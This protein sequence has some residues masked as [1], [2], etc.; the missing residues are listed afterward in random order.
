MAWADLWLSLPREWFSLTQAR[1]P[2][3]GKGVSGGPCKL[4]DSRKH[5]A[6]IL[7]SL[8]LPDGWGNVDL[9][10]QL[11]LEARNNRRLEAELDA[12]GPSSGVVGAAR[13][14][15]GL[16]ALAQ[17][18]PSPSWLRGLVTTQSEALRCLADQQAGLLICSD[19]LE[20]GNGFALVAEALRQ[21]PDL[22]VLMILSERPPNGR[23][24]VQVGCTAVILEAE[25]GTESQPLSQALQATASGVPYRSA[26]VERLLAAPANTADADSMA[27]LT[28]REE[29]VLTLIISG[30][31]DVEIA[32]RLCL[33]PQTV[34]GYGKDIR[35][36]FGAR[37]RV[38]RLGK[39]LRNAMG[40]RQR[41][42]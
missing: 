28:P 30:C 33:S 18:L 22:R 20:Q 10:E 21:V 35:R 8:K 3:P 36:K 15:L 6:E 19:Q 1:A 24:A 31:T 29:E 38:E 7:V 12:S 13:S 34:R 37:S 41:L 16:L 42:R 27:R 25:L 5:C 2:R 32:Q 14:H 26:A 9:T 23:R 11:V 17:A 39:A 4:F 40:R